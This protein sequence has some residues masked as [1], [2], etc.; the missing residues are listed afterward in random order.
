MRFATPVVTANAITV[1][2]TA[3]PL[4][5]LA[6][7]EVN[8]EIANV[9]QTIGPNITNFD[10]LSLF[11]ALVASTTQ[12]GFNYNLHQLMPNNNSYAAGPFL[13]DQYIQAVEKRIIK[14]S[15]EIDV[16]GFDSG[17]ICQDAAFWLGTF[18]NIGKQQANG[19]ND[20]YKIHAAGLILGLDFIPNDDNVMGLAFAIASSRIREFSNNGFTTD[21]LSYSPI[22]YGA[23]DLHGDFFLEWTVAGAINNQS[24]SRS[25]NINAN[26]FKVT[27]SYNTWQAGGK[28]NLGKNIDLTDDIYMAQVNSLQ[29]TL[30]HQSPYT[31]SGS[32]AALNV[33][34]EVNSSLLTIGTGFRLSLINNDPWMQGTPE[35]RAIVTY[36]L[37]VPGQ[38][39]DANFV[40]SSESFNVNNTAER[41]A[42]RIGTNLSFVMCYNLQL[43]LRYDFE[44]RT[45]YYDNSA[46][47]E[48]KYIF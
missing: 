1:T 22:A 17:D 21:I 27:S 43:Q 39:V 9:L 18:G 28:L 2:L 14:L 38:Y 10:Q 8:T 48:L 15:N 36:D 25:I 29:Y 19:S 37:I 26:D 41:L 7:G 45:R 35:L 40:F 24:G 20:G 23:K 34:S 3:T 46:T 42:I 13:Q 31:E 11:D 12:A 32:V 44:A 6:I 4:Q 30:F 47:L 5:N 33:S 16:L